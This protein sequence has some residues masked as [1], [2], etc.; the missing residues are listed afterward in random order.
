MIGKVTSAWRVLKA[1]ESLG[2]VGMWKARQITATAVAGFI[3]ALA[4]LAE[5]FG[6]VVP[7]DN[8]TVDQIAVGVLAAVNLYL[9]LATSRTIGLDGVAEQ[10]K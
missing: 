4:K 6:I 2:N 9:T 10:A 8:E 5:Q 7:V 3:W 1:G